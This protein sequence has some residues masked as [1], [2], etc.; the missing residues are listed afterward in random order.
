M[1]TTSPPYR[2]R[3]PPASSAVTPPKQISASMSHRLSAFQ[4]SPSPPTTTVPKSPMPSLPSTL[5]GSVS[6]RALL[7]GAT[8]SGSTTAPGN[9]AAGGNTERG[10]AAGSAGERMGGGVGYKPSN[11]GGVRE[12]RLVKSLEGKALSVRES[13]LIPNQDGAF[14]GNGRRSMRKNHH[15]L[16]RQKR[17][18]LLVDGTIYLPYNVLLYDHAV[19]RSPNLSLA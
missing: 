11:I 14:H 6:K 15:A 9:V 17:V 16:A 7:F 12:L 10:P 8:V 18:G 3:P 2:H 13:A 19:S 4:S 5:G 1:S